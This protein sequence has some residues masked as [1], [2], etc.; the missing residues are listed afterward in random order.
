M[1][2][3]I[4]IGRFKATER[5]EMTPMRTTVNATTLTASTNHV[6]DQQGEYGLAH[7]GPAQQFIYALLAQ[8]RRPTLRTLH[9]DVLAAVARF[10]AV[11]PSHYPNDGLVCQ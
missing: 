7:S 6:Y 5:V 2:Q 9:R 1:A 3:L 8:G 4:G 11:Q 10:L